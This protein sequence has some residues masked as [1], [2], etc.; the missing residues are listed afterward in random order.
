MPTID[1]IRA[2][3]TGNQRAIINAVWEY[4]S[5]HNG[6]WEW[7]PPAALYRKFANP[8]TSRGAGRDFVLSALSSIS[9]SIIYEHQEH[10]YALTFLGLLLTDQGQDGLDLLA[11]CFELVQKKHDEGLD[12][13]G[14]TIHSQEVKTALDI[15]NE[16]LHFLYELI[17]FS[18]LGHVGG[19]KEQWNLTVTHWRDEF[20]TEDNLRVYIEQQALRDYDQAL[21][22]GHSERE[23][24]LYGK[25]SRALP[26][27][28]SF[29]H[30]DEL[31]ELL[32][33]DWK[34]AQI[35][36]NA[37]AWKSCV[38]LCGSILEGMLFD[39]LSRNEPKSLAAYAKLR[40]SNPKI[41][42]HA[43]SISDLNLNAL[44]EVASE[45]KILPPGPFHLSHALRHSRNLVHPEKQLREKVDDIENE[46]NIS[47]SSMKVFLR[48]ATTI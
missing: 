33:A 28:F 17:S 37:K 36:H 46:A 40:A 47:L 30:N 3:I 11:R 39:I 34:E 14:I 43:S 4:H 32:E 26:G 8:S 12:L 41:G 42:K 19:V 16:K 20:L 18:G 5:E 38:I 6:R 2:T 44:V 25:Q 9:G 21:P 7:M 22:V 23:Q 1:E 48:I 31:R 13:K 27:E 35:V 45:L 10:Y 15:S 29:I 24:Y